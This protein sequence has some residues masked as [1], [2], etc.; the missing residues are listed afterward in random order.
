MRLIT[1]WHVPTKSSCRPKSVRKVIEQLSASRTTSR[2]RARRVVRSAALGGDL[3]P[4]PRARPRRL[5]ADRDGRD[6]RRRSPRTRARPSR[7][8]AATTSPSG[9]VGGAARRAVERRRSRRRARRRA[10]AR[11]LGAQ[12]SS[13][14]PP[15]GQLREQPLLRRRP[16]RRGR[17]EPVPR[18]ASAVPGPIAATCARL[19]REPAR[20]L[21]ARRSG[22]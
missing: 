11:A 15:G 4:E 6:A 3:E 8:R 19:G 10:A 5:R 2:R 9:G 14:R 17:L 21:V 18:S 22:S 12:R 1:P 16:R 13:T 7:R 20:E